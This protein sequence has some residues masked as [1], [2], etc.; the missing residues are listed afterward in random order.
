MNPCVIKAYLNLFLI[1]QYIIQ[2]KMQENYAI[3]ILDILLFN[4]KNICQ[5]E[6]NLVILLSLNN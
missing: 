1:F 2:L 4:Y 3:I 6:E 5:K